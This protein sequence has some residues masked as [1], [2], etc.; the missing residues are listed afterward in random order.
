VSRVR[1]AY[2]FLFVICRSFAGVYYIRSGWEVPSSDEASSTRDTSAKTTTTTTAATTTTTPTTDSGR[3][4]TTPTTTTTTTTSTTTTPLFLVNPAELGR[5]P[6]SAL[7]YETMPA[8]AGTLVLFPTFLEH[9]ADVHH[10][11][12]DRISVAFNARIALHN[13]ELSDEWPPRF[14]MPADHALDADPSLD[15]S[16]GDDA[17]DR[18][19][20][21]SSSSQSSARDGLQSANGDLSS[22]RSSS[23]SSGADTPGGVGGG[24]GGGGGGCSAGLEDD[25]EWEDD[26]DA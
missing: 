20:T 22:S 19:G 14:Y 1:H 26:D 15:F 25:V 5:H 16:G 13:T 24:G 18:V 21:S 17:A 9:A 10:G 4:T 6:H 3:D 2:S 11:V 23:S 7:A 12:G 8:A